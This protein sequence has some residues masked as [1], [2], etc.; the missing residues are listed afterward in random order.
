MSCCCIIWKY[1]THTDPLPTHTTQPFGRTFNDM[2]SLETRATRRPRVILKVF[3]KHFFSSFFLKCSIELFVAYHPKAFELKSPKLGIPFSSRS[4]L[5]SKL[6]Q[7][8]VQKKFK[9]EQVKLLQSLSSESKEI[10]PNHL[11][12]QTNTNPRLNHLRKTKATSNRDNQK[13]NKEISR[14]IQRQRRF[15]TK[16]AAGLERR[17]EIRSTSSPLRPRIGASLWIAKR[18]IG[19]PF[20]VAER[21][22][23]RR[24]GWEYGGPAS[25][26]VDWVICI[27]SVFISKI[28]LILFEI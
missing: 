2:L 10:K 6:I 9:Q 26:K 14:T 21:S 7:Q 17:S 24:Q 22:L 15:S 1:R 25:T 8:N 27:R 19:P 5:G 16:L 4:S 11:G 18:N 23:S 3:L 20:R 12:S 28:I 13:E